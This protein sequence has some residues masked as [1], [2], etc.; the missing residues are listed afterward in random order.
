MHY[1]HGWRWLAP[2]LLLRQVYAGE[3][4]LVAVELA[5]LRTSWSGR[6]L[7]PYAL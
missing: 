6:L 4:L 3:P 7:S 1:L 2:I 5:P